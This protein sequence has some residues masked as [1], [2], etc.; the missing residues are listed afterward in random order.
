MVFPQFIH[1]GAIRPLMEGVLRNALKC[2]LRDDS[3]RTKSDPYPSEEIRIGTV[4][5][6]LQCPPTWSHDTHTCNHLI[7]GWNAST[8]AMGTCLGPPCDLLLGNGAEILEG[9]PMLLQL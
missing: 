5:C 1:C 4:G 2:D 3:E 9:E 6:Q 8:R 7:D